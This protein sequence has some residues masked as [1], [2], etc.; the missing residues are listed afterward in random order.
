MSYQVEYEQ[1]PGYL[2]VRIRGERSL[3]AVI[4]VT[5]ETAEKALALHQPRLLVDVRE[6][7][8]WLQTMENYELVTRE[9]AKF[10]GK[11]IRKLAIL[12]RQHLDQPPFLETL[13]QNRGIGLRI[14]TDA[15][16]AVAWLLEGLDSK[17]A[18]E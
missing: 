13:A 18:G 15:G 17:P 11:G 6:F 1:Q 12:D 2:S 9:F 8:G 5:A 14:H 3:E 10:Q 16:A 7:T 4:A